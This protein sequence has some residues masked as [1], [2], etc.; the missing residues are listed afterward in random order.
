MRGRGGPALLAVRRGLRQRGGFVGRGGAL[1]SPGGFRG[2]GED[3]Y[4]TAWWTSCIG[5][6]VLFLYYCNGRTHFYSVCVSCFF[7]A[8]LWGRGSFGGRGRGR[9]QDRGVGTFPGH[10][11]AA[12]QPAGRLHVQDQRAPRRRAG[13]VHGPNWRRMHGIGCC[14][15]QPSDLLHSTAQLNLCWWQAHSDHRMVYQETLGTVSGLPETW[16][17]LKPNPRKEPCT[18]TTD[19]DERL[20]VSVNC[21]LL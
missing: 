8:G 11:G 14:K 18:H 21:N 17:T 20:L 1:M 2:N 4:L 10:S 13:R 16:N 15:C 9:G 3:D 19:S 5:W 6:L 7:S 12:G